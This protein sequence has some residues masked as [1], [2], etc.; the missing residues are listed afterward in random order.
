[1]RLDAQGVREREE[2]ESKGYQL[3]QFDREAV[4]KAT[5]EQ[6]FWIHF[7]LGNIFRAFQANVVQQLLN[8]GLLNR[9]LIAGEG[10]NY[11]LVREVARPHDNYHI[12]VTLK[13]DGKVEKTVI[14]S[15]VETLTVD[16]DHTEDIERLRKIFAAPSLQMVSFTITEKGYSLVDG[17]GNYLPAI[18]EDFEAGPAEAKSYMGKITALLYC[19]YRAGQQAVAMLSLDNC[20][21]NGDRLREAVC[22]YAR[23]WQEI[24]KVDSGFLA[25]LK[26]PKK[27][28][29]PYTMIDKITPRPDPSVEA[30]LRNDGIEELETVVTKNQTYVTPFVNAEETEYLVVEDAF[31]NGRPQALEQGGILFTTRETVEKVEKMKVSTCLNPLHTGLAVFGCL[32]GY[33]KIADEMGDPDLRGLVEGL[34]YREGLPVV[35]NPGVID[36][37]TFLNTVLQTRL[38][39]PFLPDSPQ[40]IAMDTSQKLGVRFGET[41]KAYMLSDNL[42][43]EDLKLVPLVLAGWLRY[44]V[45]VDDRGQTFAISADPRLQTLRLQ[46]ADLRLGKT[47]GVEKLVR[48]I[49]EDA[50][51]FGVN[52]YEA[53]LAERVC[54]YLKELLAGVGAVRKTLHKYVTETNVN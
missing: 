17:N 14:G 10:Y 16:P 19:R 42:C 33:T 20:A 47:E 9:G 40:R 52:L 29:F 7:G 49:L 4:Q 23:H 34:G 25:Y 48:P 39:N 1:M 51:I 35:I 18:V 41:I 6:P 5:Q 15:I 45:G 31:P 26:N 37:K 11:E 13:A 12:L 28:S 22:A 43:V 50:T 38:P 44:L 32:L 3:P 54:G 21:R 24:G 2:W 53:E 36:P 46:L 30:V 8:Q 27:V